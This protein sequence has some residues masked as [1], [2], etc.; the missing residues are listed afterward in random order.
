MTITRRSFV[1]LLSVCLAG[2][3]HHQQHHPNSSEALI[4]TTE[5]HSSSLFIL[6]Y[7]YCPSADVPTIEES[8]KVNLLSRFYSLV[9]L[10]FNK[11]LILTHSHQF[12]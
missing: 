11:L 5:N 4:I 12:T 7:Y 9:L 10:D 1:F 6:N 3:D 2:S 8:L